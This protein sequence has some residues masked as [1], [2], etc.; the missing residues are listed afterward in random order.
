MSR[1]R[2]ILIAAA[3]V[4]A[5]SATAA[6]FAFTGDDAPRRSVRQEPVVTDERE[7]TVN[8]VDRDYAPRDLTIRHGATITWVW[9]GDL[10]HNVVEDRGRFES[11]LLR[12]GDKWSLTFDDAG[13]FYYYCTLHHVMQGTIRVVE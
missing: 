9:D 5:G 2:L 6:F 12:D 1:G 8:V 13:E 3:A 7:V 4:L 11:P 10:P